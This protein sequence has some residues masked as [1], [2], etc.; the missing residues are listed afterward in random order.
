MSSSANR[1]L[2]YKYL[3]EPR[4]KLPSYRT[5]Q[6][7]AATSTMTTNTATSTHMWRLKAHPTDKKIDYDKPL[8]LSMKNKRF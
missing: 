2:L 1:G 5:V 7:S 6:S 8:D 4:D 3:T